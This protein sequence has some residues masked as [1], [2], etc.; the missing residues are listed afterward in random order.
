M[1]CNTCAPHP[2]LDGNGTFTELWNDIKADWFRLTG[3]GEVMCQPQPGRSEPPTTSWEDLTVDIL[4]AAAQPVYSPAY[5]VDATPP[6][7]DGTSFLD[8][9]DKEVKESESGWGARFHGAT[10]E[11]TTGFGSEVE[12]IPED[13]PWLSFRFG[14]AT[15]KGAG[16]K[17]GPFDAPGTYS[18]IPGWRGPDTVEETR[19]GPV[20]TPGEYHKAIHGESQAWGAW[21][22]LGFSF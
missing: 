7:P 14:M 1:T 16:G 12:Y 9:L 4:A 19:D 15:W 11:D 5:N 8:L 17:I 22:T 13:S 10:Q 2:P 18:S 6:R 20:I 3:A 21:L